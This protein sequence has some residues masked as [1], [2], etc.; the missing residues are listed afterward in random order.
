MLAAASLIALL[1][2]AP[3]ALATR[4]PIAGGI[5]DFHLKRGMERKL[6]NLGVQV[7][8]LGATT[9]SGRKIGMQIDDGKLDPTDA[10]GFVDN[11]GGFKLALG[12]RGVPITEV[13]VNTVKKAVYAKIA[14][15]RMQLAELSPYTSG[16]Q[17]FG[18]NVKA[19]KVILTEKAVRRISNR[20]GLKG[21]KRLNPGRVLSNGYVATVPQTVTVL[22]QGNAVLDGNLATLGKFAKKGVKLPAGISAIA[23]A[24]KPTPTSF[25]FPITG[26]TLAPDA[27]AG[28]VET[29]GGVQIAKEGG[30]TMKLIG[31]HAD[32]S[33]KTATVEIEITPAPPFPGA[34]GRSSIADLS[35]TGATVVADPN[36][37]LITVQNAEATLQAVAAATLNDVFNQPEPEPASNF[38]V[39]DS[40]GKF[41]FT[42]QAQ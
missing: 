29:A 36:T 27:S 38:V 12:N 20:L 7:T 16:R 22:A 5:T 39:G 9:V 37:R 13:T 31:I 24:L 26:G 25:Q 6:S 42:A 3:S 4:D 40:F 28:T 23:P 17:G 2:F 35:L 21:S 33:A 19:P 8:G 32:F 34:V 10:Q 41:S 15:A 11:R 1:A 30:A 18:A 14:G